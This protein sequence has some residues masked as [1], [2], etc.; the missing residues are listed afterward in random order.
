MAKPNQA[1]ADQE[2]R[3]L[4]QID[5]AHAAMLFATHLSSK[6]AEAGAIGIHPRLVAACAREA[7]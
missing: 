2:R 7:V 5:R 1:R 6:L 4:L 3:E